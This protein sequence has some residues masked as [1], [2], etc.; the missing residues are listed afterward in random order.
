MSMTPENATRSWRDLT[1]QLTPEQVEELERYEGEID[2]I[3]A[4]MLVTPP[5]SPREAMLGRARA[6]A[7]ENELDALIGDV[8]L[9]AGA[10][11]GDIW[12]GDDPARV[13][14]GQSHGITGTDVLVWTSAI[15]WADG[16]IAP[17]Q[18]EPPR[19]HVEGAVDLNSDQARELAAILLEA[20]AEVD[21]WTTT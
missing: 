19:V 12:E 20:A 14:M 15:Q 10:L 2:E 17:E 16:R 5:L 11:F 13:I 4:L 18:P 6:C 8:P 7:R 3:V 21:G 9:P 1:N